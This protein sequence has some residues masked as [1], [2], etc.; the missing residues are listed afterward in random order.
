VLG[1]EWLVPADGAGAPAALSQELMCEIKGL[2]ARGWRNP[3]GF[4]VLKGSQ[5]VLRERPS[6]DKYPLPRQMRDQLRSDGL[7]VEGNGALVFTRDVEFASPSAAASVIHG[8]HA[9]GLIAWKNAKGLTLK[10]IEAA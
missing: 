10:D 5:A 6:T 2:R 8:G 1:V 9:N 3:S 7:L 4:V